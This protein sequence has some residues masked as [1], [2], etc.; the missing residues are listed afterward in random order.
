MRNLKTLS[1]LFI[2]L[3]FVASAAYG[4]GGQQQMQAL[5]PDSVSQQELQS[6]VQITDSIQVISQKVQDDIRNLVQDEG[7]EFERFQKI[8]MSKQNPQMAQNVEAT[9]EEEKL[10]QELQPKIMSMSQ[11]VQMKSMQIVQNSDLSMQRFQQIFRTLQAN[12]ELAKR[13]QALKN[14]QQQ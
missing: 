11:E 9:P 14:Q 10:L 13:F 5:D 4:Q 2:G 3:F 12:P 8:M 6:M 7:M 1:I